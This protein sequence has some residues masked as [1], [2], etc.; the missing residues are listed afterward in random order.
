MSHI[1]DVAPRADASEDVW[2][3]RLYIAGQSPKSLRAV[4]NLTA[5]CDEHLA[6]RSELTIID[7]VEQPSLARADDIVAI[8]TLVRELPAPAHQIIGDLSHTERVLAGLRIFPG[9]DR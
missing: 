3:L 2:R 7:L 4:A 6:G 5:I 8:P 9:R 1:R